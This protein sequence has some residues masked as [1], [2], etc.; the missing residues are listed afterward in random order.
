MVRKMDNSYGIVLKHG[1]WVIRKI[2]Q[3]YVLHHVNDSKMKRAVYPGSLVQALSLLH[4]KLLLDR[5][6]KDRDKGDIESFRNAIIETNQE[7]E[8]LL[9]PK[10]NTRLNRMLGVSGEER[11]DGRETGG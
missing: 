8:K 2:P 10:A 9:S 3:C 4:E 5:R 1:G 11:G 7:F 6:F